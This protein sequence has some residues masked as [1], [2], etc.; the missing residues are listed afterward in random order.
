MDVR[1]CR[2]L[3]KLDGWAAD[4]EYGYGRGR[5]GY[6]IEKNACTVA[7]VDDH[8]NDQSGPSCLVRISVSFHSPIHANFNAHLPLE[9]PPCNLSHILLPRPILVFHFTS[10]QI[11]LFSSLMMFDSKSIKTDGISVGAMVRSH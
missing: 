9:C 11:C 6:E 7:H 3:D 4:R 10:Q 2:H 8:D 1:G 5:S